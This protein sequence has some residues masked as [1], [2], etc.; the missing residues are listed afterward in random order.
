LSRSAPQAST[1]EV[2]VLAVNRS[3]VDTDSPLGE[4]FTRGDRVRAM[5]C[6]SITSLQVGRDAVRMA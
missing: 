6:S 2:D 3:A 5:K 1:I 4:Q